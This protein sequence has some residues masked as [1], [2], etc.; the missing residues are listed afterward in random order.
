MNFTRL[1]TQ[2]IRLKAQLSDFGI[3]TMCLDNGGE[4]TSRAF[5]YYCLTIGIT[6]EDLVLHVHTQNGLAESLIKRLQM[7]ARPMVMRTKLTVTILGML[8]VLSLL[9]SNSVKHHDDSKNNKLIKFFENLRNQQLSKELPP[10]F[11][12]N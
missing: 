5:N 12:K 3:K 11:R 9:Y 7:F 8:F 6:V 4:F 10:N 2:I 1:L